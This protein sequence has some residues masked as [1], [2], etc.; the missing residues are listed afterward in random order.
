MKRVLDVGQCDFDHSEI[1]R[2]LRERFQVEADRAARLEDTLSAMSRGRYAL[3]LVN[4]LLDGDGS[5]GLAIIQRLKKDAAT[6]DVPVMLVSNH[7][8]AQAAATAEG[9]L[10]GFGKAALG[11]PETAA[12]VAA[13]LALQSGG[14]S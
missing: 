10:P 9:A 8:D 7:A 3:V 14:A 1:S 13:A 2:M 5:E 12:R 11:S 6:R 4:R